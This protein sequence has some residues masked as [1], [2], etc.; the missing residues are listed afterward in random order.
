MREYKEADRPH[1]W[2][3][4]EA[5]R[6]KDGIVLLRPPG[7]GIKH[8]SFVAVS[9]GKL[10]GFATVKQ[11]EKNSA[12]YLTLAMHPKYRSPLFSLEISKAALRKA[13]EAGITDIRAIT[14]KNLTHVV[15][16]LTILGFKLHEESSLQETHVEYRLTVKK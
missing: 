2:K 5:V 12:G 7:G 1:L 14:M 15:E 3:V 16:G 4:L 10:V 6:K 9:R 13:A 8:F 11:P